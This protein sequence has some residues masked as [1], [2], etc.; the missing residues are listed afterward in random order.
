MEISMLVIGL[1]ISFLG[2]GNICSVT[3]RG[4]RDFYQEVNEKVKG[5]TTI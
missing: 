2:R 3:V 1:M 5:S 4:T